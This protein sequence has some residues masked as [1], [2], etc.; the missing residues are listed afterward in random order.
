MRI[1]LLAPSNYEFS[2]EIYKELER[3]KH[4][5]KFIEDKTFACDY[6]LSYDNKI[7]RILKYIIGRSTKKKNI[8]W[9]KMFNDGGELHE[10]HCDLLLCI[11]GYSLCKSFFLQL[12]RNNPD[13]RL[14]YYLWDSCRL[15]AF[16]KNFRYFDK[17]FTFDIEDAKKFQIEYLPMFW[18]PV[19]DGVSV[20][21]KP[22]VFFVGSIHSDRYAVLKR[23]IHQLNNYQIDY[24]IKLYVPSNKI[25]LLKIRYGI[26][27]LFRYEN[28]L[29]DI[30]C[31]RKGKEN[32][33]FI[34]FKPI[35]LEDFN[36]ELIKS[37][38]TIDIEQPCQTALTPRF[39]QALACG[40]KIITTNSWIIKE[41][42][43]NSDVISVIDREQPNVDEEFLFRSIEP[44]CSKYDD[45]RIDK[46][47]DNFLI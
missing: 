24:Y 27:K 7:K 43:Y 16:H 40:K 10:Y 36:K 37:S 31:I 29:N 35:P 13:I 32:A 41:P 30:Y 44:I 14:V 34:T 2:F 39:I 3:K 19:S 1:L 20:S 11:N 8:Y 46:W 22:R 21:E 15:Y 26:N 23:I 28:C 17:C 38:C 33:S 47:L 12:M 42:F 9:R 18:I 45:L 25:P 4:E 6:Y 5:V